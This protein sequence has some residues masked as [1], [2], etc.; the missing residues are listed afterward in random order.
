VTTETSDKNWDFIKNHMIAH[1]FDD[2][3]VKGATR[4]ANTQVNEQMHGPLKDSYEDHINFKDIAGQVRG[5]LL[6]IELLCN[7]GHVS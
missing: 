2:I 3:L 4:N 6:W 5:Y 7:M 1:V